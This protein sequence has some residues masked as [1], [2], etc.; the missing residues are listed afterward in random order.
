MAQEN[1]NNN[2]AIVES[3]VNESNRLQETDPNKSLQ[4]AVMALSMIM[5]EYE[6]EKKRMEEQ[7]GAGGTNAAETASPYDS[8][9]GKESASAKQDL[10]NCEHSNDAYK[11]RAVHDLEKEAERQIKL[12]KLCVEDG[13]DFIKEGYVK[14]A[15]WAKKMISDFGDRIKVYLKQTYLS[16]TAYVDDETFEQ[17]DSPQTVRGF[18]LDSIIINDEEEAEENNNN[19]N[20]DN[21]EKKFYAVVGLGFPKALTQTDHPGTLTME[22]VEYNMEWIMAAT[23]KWKWLE[24]ETDIFLKSTIMQT[25]AMEMVGRELTEID[26]PIPEDEMPTLKELEVEMMSDAERIF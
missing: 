18:D 6:E 4:M 14:F 22:D 2:L 20:D 7:Q 23:E 10:E 9:Y 1:N 5:V 12:M 15:D 19:N 17:M 13:L 8:V 21:G 24:G 11:L 16:M 3:L 26:S 25:A